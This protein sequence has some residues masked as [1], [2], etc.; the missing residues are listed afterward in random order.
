MD[1]EHLAIVDLVHFG[2]NPRKVTPERLEQLKASLQ[3]FGLFKPLLVWSDANVVIGGNQ[4]LRAM[5]ELAMGKASM[6]V[7]VSAIPCVRFNGTEAEARII[8]LR[9]NA[10]DGET[11]WDVLPDYMAS[12]RGLVGEDYDLT[13]TGFDAATVSDLEE[14]AA[15]VDANLAR[16]NSGQ[17]DEDGHPVQP[18]PSGPPEDP[19]AES[20]YVGRKYARVVIGNIRGQIEVELY[21]QFLQAFDTYSK[22]LNTTVIGEILTTILQDAEGARREA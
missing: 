4:R 20:Q 7:D 6:K 18:A 22:R 14:L 21:R 10:Q 5:N 8:A 15:S 12:L 16:F 17:V 13:L 19:K 1:I 2:D 3:E 9:D 11:D